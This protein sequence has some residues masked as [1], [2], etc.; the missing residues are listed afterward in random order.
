MC[1][2]CMYV[3]QG[4]VC[5]P[6]WGG[7]YHRSKSG[8]QVLLLDSEELGRGS[9]A[10]RTDRHFCF[11]HRPPFGEIWLC[12]APSTFLALLSRGGPQPG[13]HPLAAGAWVAISKTLLEFPSGSP[14]RPRRRG[15]PDRPGR[16]RAA[17]CGCA[18]SPQPGPRVPQLLP[19]LP[20][21]RG[22][23]RSPAQRRA[24]GSAASLRRRGCGSVSPIVPYPARP[25]PPRLTLEVR[26]GLSAPA[27]S[28]CGAGR[29]GP[30]GARAGSG[31]R[32]GVG[33]SAARHGRGAGGEARGGPGA[34]GP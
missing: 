7:V 33:G 29:R 34:A 14:S 23:A 24:A 3:C 28:R 12:T 5:V 32:A 31:W 20:P 17:Q 13:C 19:R 27:G 16:P 6:R 25:S 22:P 15:G 26:R 11:L 8:P 30:A 1:V 21:P 4:C 10:G 9:P 2:V 18:L